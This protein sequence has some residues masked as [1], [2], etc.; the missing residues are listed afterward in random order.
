MNKL[1]TE[2]KQAIVEKVLAKDGR[3]KGEIA[4]AYNIGYSTLSK[5]IKKYRDYGTINVH[6]SGSNNQALS[7]SERFQHLIATA[8][9]DKAA[10]GVYCREN[11]LYSFKLTE[12]K[13]AFMTEKSTEKQHAN[14]AELKALRIENKQLKH[15]VR[16]KDSALAEA[17]A[18]LILKK[19]AALIW[20]ETEA[21]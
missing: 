10:I 19:K 16:R 20:G 2:A 7:A 5:W 8:A 4:K 15:E 3:T 13:A 9:L 14:I 11:G 6:K 18:L 17:S 1:S 21:D 12:W